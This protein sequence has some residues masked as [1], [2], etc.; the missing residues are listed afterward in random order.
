MKV[1]VE[2]IVKYHEFF[3]K[4]NSVSLDAI[5]FYENGKKVCI[6]KKYIEEFR[7]TG[8]TNIYFILMDIYKQGVSND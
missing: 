7:F 5:D 3:T 8:L 4:L 1:N 2:D 6:S